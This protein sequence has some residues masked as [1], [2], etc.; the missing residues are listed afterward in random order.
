MKSDPKPTSSKA[1]IKENQPN[2]TRLYPF[3]QDCKKKSGL[4]FHRNVKMADGK[5]TICP[6][7]PKGQAYVDRFNQFAAT[8]KGQRALL[9]V[10]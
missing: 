2:N 8:P 10:E 6:K 5:T 9:P 3:C 4:E 1:G 7:A